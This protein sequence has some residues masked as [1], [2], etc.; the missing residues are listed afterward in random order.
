MSP[1]ALVLLLALT[2]PAAWAVDALRA[3]APLDAPP[4]QAIETASGMAYVVV[5]P[6]PDASRT[7]R[8][9]YV[10]Y[11]ADI[12][13]ADGVTR[14]NSR[15]EGAQVGSIR[16]LALAQ[17]GLARALLTT[18][19]GETRRWWIQADR[20]KP[21]YPGMPDLPHV[22]DLT[23]VGEKS[24]PIDTPAD[25]AAVPAEAV[26]TP[27]GLAYKVLKRGDG[28]D[29]PTLSSII[30]IHYSGW[31]TDGKLFDS[32]VVRNERAVFP[33]GELIP[34][35]QEGVPLMSRGDTFRFWVP[36]SLAYDSQPSPG[37]PRGM[38]VFDITLYD[39]RAAP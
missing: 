1:R 22:I 29:K 21:G 30:D 14:A 6:G 34:G 25:V 5:K 32:S 13:S 8:G 3:P 36:G 4:P 26:R 38:L 35:W 10:E 24:S 37:A 20:L 39:F 7:V 16:S 15:Q 17:P 27:S 33:L 18:P 19:I 28:G 2:C 9:D 23:V 31:T 11:R 12:W